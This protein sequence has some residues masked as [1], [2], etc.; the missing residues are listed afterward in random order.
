MDRKKCLETGLVLVACVIVAPVFADKSDAPGNQA[1]SDAALQ[2]A[3]NPH[4][5]FT[6]GRIITINDYYTRHKRPGH[7]RPGGCPPGLAKKNNGCLPPGQAKKWRRGEPLPPGVIFHDLPAALMAE[8]GD[9]P[10]G[11]RVVRVDEDV[12]LIGI[13]TGLVID[14]LEL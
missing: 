12:L 10:E 6:D 14:A 7:K 11:Q 2:Q 13:A 8:L 1:K 3:V 5:Y 4:T 9:V